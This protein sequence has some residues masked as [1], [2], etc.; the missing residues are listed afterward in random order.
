MTSDNEE[1]RLKSAETADYHD[2]V[3][4][5][6]GIIGAV[7]ALGFSRFGGGDLKILLVDRHDISDQSAHAGR[8]YALSHASK[9][10]FEMLGLW[11]EMEEFVQ[12]IEEIDITDSALDSP[13][14]PVFLNFT[15]EIEM[16]W[17]GAFI[18]EHEALAGPLYKALAGAA[19]LRVRTP[20]QIETFACSLQGASLII[21]GDRIETPL[22]IGAD[23]RGSFVR[24]RMGIDV[25]RSDYRQDGIVVTVGLSEPHGGRAVQ[26]FLPAGPFAILPLKGDRA[27]LVWTE[28]RGATE[29]LMALDDDDFMEE[30]NLRFSPKLGRV[31]LLGPRRHFPLSLLLAHE[32]VT[33]RVALVGDA[34]HGVHPLAGQ[35]MNIGLRDVAALIEIVIETRRL[36]LDHGGAIAL[37]RY[38]Q[39]RRFDGVMSAFA[40]D[41][42]NRL[43]GSENHFVKEAR[44][45]GLRLVDR[46]APLKAFFVKEAAGV[47]GEV[48]LLMQGKIV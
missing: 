15:G 40:M 2:L 17:P 47:N 14:R 26:H 21:D 16:G 8:A 32:F 22:V 25:F 33:E 27:S 28:Q 34:A 45:F 37:A 6:G 9:V 13:L 43:F 48:P 35:G 12:P 4:V 38:Q 36:G 24:E 23:G 44:G 18:I 10:L 1:I 39:W 41:G 11:G 31:S 5:G 30:I 46:L 42:L 20:C 7:A 3:I 19:G 29:A